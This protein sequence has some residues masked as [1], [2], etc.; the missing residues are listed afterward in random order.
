MAAQKE[1][2]LALSGSVG[3]PPE[4]KVRKVEIQE[5]AQAAKSA[6]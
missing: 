3:D 5:P 2:R 4:A 6:A 1:T